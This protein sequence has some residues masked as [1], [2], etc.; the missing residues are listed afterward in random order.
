MILDA[1]A[2]I[3]RLLQNQLPLLHCDLQTTQPVEIVDCLNVC[4]VYEQ[5][6]AKCDEKKRKV[7]KSPPMVIAR[8]MHSTHVYI[9]TSKCTEG[10]KLRLQTKATW[11]SI[12]SFP[13]YQ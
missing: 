4:R 1:S 8:W 9:V 3:Q 11:F 13:K 6:Q 12:L 10:S 5:L 7:T 2:K